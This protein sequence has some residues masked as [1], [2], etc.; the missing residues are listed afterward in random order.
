MQAVGGQEVAAPPQERA[1]AA[2]QR[3]E[4]YGLHLRI[5]EPDIVGQVLL[6]GRA[7]GLDAHGGCADLSQALRAE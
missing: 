3:L 4:G 1:D 2:L 5:L 6:R 7:G